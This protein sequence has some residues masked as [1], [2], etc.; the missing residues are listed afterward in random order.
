MLFVAN[1]ESVYIL[2]TPGD[3]QHSKMWLTTVSHYITFDFQA[4]SDVKLALS[5]NPFIT[6]DNVYEIIIGGWVN[7]KS[8]I[9][10]GLFGT[11]LA[12]S[13][14]TN[15][16]SCTES[17]SFWVGWEN[18][19]MTVG[20]GSVYGQ[21][22]FMFYNDLNPHIVTAV[23]LSSGINDVG[24]GTYQVRQDEGKDI[25]KNYTYLCVILLN[26]CV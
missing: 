7:T 8:V 2:K 9:R 20:R 1:N 3:N 26:I 23:S 25:R 5:T 22:V 12:E 21:E 19:N 10:R 18:G 14:I 15:L 13:N 11:Q 24:N 6:T 16:V 17:R 4:C